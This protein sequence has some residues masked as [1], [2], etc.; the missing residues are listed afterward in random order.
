[1]KIVAKGE[2]NSVEHYNVEQVTFLYQNGICV[3][4]TQGTLQEWSE[5]YSLPMVG[6]FLWKA[7]FQKHKSII[8]F[9]GETSGLGEFVD[10]KLVVSKRL[11]QTKAKD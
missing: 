4:Y 3:Q 10:F 2:I 6:K 5:E 9:D 11:K 1:M 7:F 8:S